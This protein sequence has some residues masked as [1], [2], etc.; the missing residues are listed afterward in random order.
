V[1][2]D[3]IGGFEGDLGRSLGD[4]LRGLQE[5]RQEIA[6]LRAENEALRREL[7]HPAL[8]PSDHK[9]SNRSR[10]LRSKP[11]PE[12]SSEVT[13]LKSLFR[14]RLDVYA[15]RWTSSRTGKSGYSPAVRGGF[16]ARQSKNKSYLPLTDDILEAHLAG[17]LAIG[18]YPLLKD[19]TCWFLATDF[20]GPAWELDALAYLEAGARHGVPVYLERSRSGAG[21]HAWIFFATPVSAVAARRL[22]AGLLREAMV[23]RGEIDLQSYDRFFP[24]QDFLPK[25]SFGNLIALPLQGAARAQG[26]TEFLDEKTMQPHPDQGTFLK[27]IGRM[28][29]ATLERALRSLPHIKVGADAVKA[30]IHSSRNLVPAPDRVECTRQAMLSVTKSGLPPWLLSDL[31]HLASLHNPQFYERQRLRLSTFRVPRLVRCY[32][33]DLSDIHVPRGLLEDLRE[34]MRKSGTR[35]HVDDRRY[36]SRDLSLQFH[37]ELAHAQQDAVAALLKHDMGILVAPPG[38]GKTVMACAVVAARSVPTIVL[39]H[40]KPLVDQWRT[41]LTDLLDLPDAEVGQIGGGRTRSSGVIDVAMIQSLTRMDDAETLLGEYGLVVVDECHHLP[42]VSFEAVVRQAPGRYF[43]GLTATP[44]RR[45]GL[46][47]IISMQLGPIRHR[48]GIDN[49]AEA[50]RSRELVI[51][52]SAFSFEMTEVTSIQEVFSA[53]VEDEARNKLI[54]EDVLE[55]LSQGRRCLILSQ[56]REH[57]HAHAEILR[58]RGKTP[59]VIDGS[60]PKKAREEV[61]STI[62]SASHDDE[63]CVISTGQYLGEGFD[64]PQ[65]DT[66]FLAFP[67]SFKGRVVQYVGRLLRAHEAKENVVVFDY[68]DLAVPV[69][70]K[71]HYKRIRAYKGLGFAISQSQ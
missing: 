54:C 10:P 51:R 26:N 7:G 45:D 56:R 49:D 14:S 17:D 32:G 58:A 37:G 19:D 18:I 41:Q 15:V 70:K 42:A 6:R 67:V 68:A 60:L 63:L 20:D 36:S 62:A 48:L 28:S 23:D 44:Y 31:K 27:E 55:A 46:E 29:P 53:L 2:D 69:L 52:E 21:G 25:G 64:C 39:V 4:L 13:L 11:R 71:M 1:V 30:R 8:R 22:G 50:A 24:S 65:L 38:M 40:R 43:L 3:L 12:P 33:E 47:G 59:L 57:C 5:S 16:A 9:D 61:L 66:L 35:L 34:L